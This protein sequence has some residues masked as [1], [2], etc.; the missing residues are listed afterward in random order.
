MAHIDGANVSDTFYSS[1]LVYDQ[2]SVA[3]SVFA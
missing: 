2:V 3:L 1:W